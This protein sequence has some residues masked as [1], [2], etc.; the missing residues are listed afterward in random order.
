MRADNGRLKGNL[1]ERT[2]EFAVSVID[3]YSLLPRR[4]V[5][6]VLGDQ[7]LRSGTSVGR[8]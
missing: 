6:Q 1:N 3:L 8:K 4:R 5:A 7:L 2:K